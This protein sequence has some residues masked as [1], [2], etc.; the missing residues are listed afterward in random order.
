[1]R[2]DT[3]QPPAKCKRL[4]KVIQYT[5]QI[6]AITQQPVYMYLRSLLSIVVIVRLLC[7]LKAMV[8]HLICYRRSH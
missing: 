4:K 3:I 1:M 5:I 8:I 7:K 2:H 6:A